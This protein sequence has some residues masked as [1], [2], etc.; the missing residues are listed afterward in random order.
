MK[1]MI[2]TTLVATTVVIVMATYLVGYRNGS[3]RGDVPL[4]G[5]ARAAEAGKPTPAAARY[6]R[7]DAVKDRAVYYPGTEDL[8]PDEMRVIACGSG[9]PVPSPNQGAACFLVELGNSI[10]HESLI[11][12]GS[13]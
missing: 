5:E 8:A 1:R 3:I 7:T 13:G 12:R 2:G 6:S 10:S 4:V 9:M 11:T